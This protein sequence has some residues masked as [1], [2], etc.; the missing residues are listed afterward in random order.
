MIYVQHTGTRDILPRLQSILARQGIRAAVL[1][2]NTVSP[3]KR[4]AWLADRVKDGIDA[5]LALI[6]N[7]NVTLDALLDKLLGV[8]R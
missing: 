3:E 5:C 1:R 8:A 4:E 2:A 6:D 7:P